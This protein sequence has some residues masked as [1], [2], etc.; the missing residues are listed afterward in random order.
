MGKHYHTEFFSAELKM[1]T[2]SLPPFD[3]NPKDNKETAK[4]R[5]W[6]F[7]SGKTGGANKA[8][9]HGGL[10]QI[11]AVDSE[12]KIYLKQDPE[13]DKNICEVF[14]SQFMR[15]I[16]EE[17]GEDPNIIANV[18]YVKTGKRNIY[19]ASEVFDGY[20]DLFLDA[21][22]AYQLPGY[23]NLRGL[24]GTRWQN[25]PKKRP[26]YMEHNNCIDYMMMAGRYRN[27]IPGLA[28]R[29]IMDDP[30]LHFEN[31]GAV[32]KERSGDDD[33][34]PII[35]NGQF[36]GE[37]LSL[38]PGK[39]P[40]EVLKP[41]N[42]INYYSHFVNDP[43]M[44]FKE[45]FIHHNQQFYLIPNINNTRSA[46][47]DFGAALGDFRP[48]NP[49]KF[50]G[51]I[52]TS[53][54]LN[55]IRYRP[56]RSGP[57]SYHNQISPALIEGNE[58]FKTLACFSMIDKR[59]IEEKI[60]SEIDR[61]YEFYSDQPWILLRFAERIGVSIPKGA[62]DNPERIAFYAK[63][64]L[65]NNFLARQNHAKELF[66]QHFCRLDR[67]TQLNMFNG[68]FDENV[69]LTGLKEKTMAQFLHQLKAEHQTLF[70]LF[71]HIASLKI[72]MKF[73]SARLSS[74]LNALQ[75]NLHRR[76][77]QAYLK[78]TLQ[79]E[80]NAIHDVVFN[81]KEL[82]VDF[83]KTYKLL[84]SESDHKKKTSA[85]E[86]F[87]EKAKLFEKQCINTSTNQKFLIAACTLVGTLIGVLVG[88]TAGLAMG[89]VVGGASGSVIPVFGN[90]F[91][92]VAAGS[93]GG[94]I[95]AVKCAGLGGMIGAAAGACLLGS[96]CAYGAGKYSRYLMFHESDRSVE[97]LAKDSSDYLEAKLEVDAEHQPILVLTRAY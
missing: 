35:E 18:D 58:F 86:H 55:L 12:K 8:G 66:L 59:K 14:A 63:K 23:E 32:P 90:I 71:D 21:Y 7:L 79:Q 67:S 30:D 89:M 28:F 4:T 13:Q 77:A 85:I 92:A 3:R 45:A 41:I 69:E 1:S 54:L 49:R 94:I 2:G 31:I 39:V 29:A 83:D 64:Y 84:N 38:G 50:D 96:T 56:S 5:A 36:T 73:A 75:N 97:T 51:H 93:L 27:L 88:A 25:L 16:A 24:V 46:S 44:D 20:R 22:L 74:D 70:D 9:R 47:I 53:K 72:K 76:A 87:I 43:F 40:D 78:G 81:T 37:V 80:Y 11:K 65:Y 95:T 42:G 15:F 57:P 91:A 48:I 26:Q 52:H 6:Q 17:I 10:Y 19:V 82:L 60:N 62:E 68:Y 33:L 34:I 61:A